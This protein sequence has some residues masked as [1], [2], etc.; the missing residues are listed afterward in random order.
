MTGRQLTQPAVAHP[1]DY[2]ALGPCLW[3]CIH[4]MANLLSKLTVKAKRIL[5]H[6]FTKPPRN[7]SRRSAG[8][9]IEPSDADEVPATGNGPRPAPEHIEHTANPSVSTAE[10]LGQPS[11]VHITSES[12]SDEPPPTPSPGRQPRAE[13]GFPWLNSVKL[14]LEIF[15]KTLN[16]VP[17]P[18]LRGAIGGVLKIIERY[19]VSN[20]VYSVC[21]LL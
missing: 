17:A 1:S 8:E 12:L 19:D 13:G 7:P 21:L 6:I 14:A 18:G 3:N 16:S 11:D 20:F 5:K 9:A 2:F 10:T 15:E 4:I